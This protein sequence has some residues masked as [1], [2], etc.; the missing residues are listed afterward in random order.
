MPRTK[1]SKNKK[2]LEKEVVISRQL[3]NDILEEQK[4]RAYE[5]GFDEGFNTVMESNQRRKR[6][7]FEQSMYKLIYVISLYVISFMTGLYT[8]IFIEAGFGV[9]AMLTGVVAVV[10]LI[11][12][13][14]SDGLL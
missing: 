9:L 5:L 4:A 6:R 3:Y 14:K 11:N 12:A 7:K 13:L 1:G 2:T 8:E 10:C